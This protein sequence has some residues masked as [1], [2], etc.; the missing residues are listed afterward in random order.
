MRQ[1]FFGKSEAPLKI[2]SFNGGIH[3]GLAFCSPGP[4]RGR[5]P[6]LPFIF[7][8]TKQRYYK[9]LEGMRQFPG[10]LSRFMKFRQCINNK[11]PQ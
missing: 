4:V 9:F 11:G 7:P 3:R 6:A 5:S 1:L 10:N 8:M 2:G